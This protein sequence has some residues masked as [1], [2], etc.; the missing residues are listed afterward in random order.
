MV[1]DIIEGDTLVFKNTREDEKQVRIPMDHKDAP[2]EFFF[3]HI[4]YKPM[5]STPSALTP[6]PM[7]ST[8]QPSTPTPPK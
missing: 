8:T 7:A 2:D 6:S 3:V 4:N 5:A 1:L